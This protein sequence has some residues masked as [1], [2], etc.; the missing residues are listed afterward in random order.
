MLTGVFREVF[1]ERGLCE[2]HLEYVYLVEEQ[3][4]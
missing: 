1:L 4:D 2:L 3:D